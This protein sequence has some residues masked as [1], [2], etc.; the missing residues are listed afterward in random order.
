L[1]AD[2]ENAGMSLAMADL[3]IAAIALNH[4][5]SLA[6]HNHRHFSRISGLNLEDW[7]V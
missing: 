4:Q 2:L 6:T 5:V 7:L 1:K 3:Q